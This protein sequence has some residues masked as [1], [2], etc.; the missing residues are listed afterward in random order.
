MMKNYLHVYYE[1]KTTNQRVWAEKY[2]SEHDKLH[3][4]PLQCLELCLRA[5][6]PRKE[7]TSQKFFQV[8]STREKD[9][10]ITLKEDFAAEA[11]C[12]FDVDTVPPQ[13]AIFLT[14][15]MR[16]AVREFW[17]TKWGMVYTKDVRKA[18]EKGRKGG[19]AKGEGKAK[20]GED[21]IKMTEEEFDQLI[22]PAEFDTD[23]DGRWKEKAKAPYD[24]NNVYKQ[25]TR[26]PH[27]YPTSYIYNLVFYD[28]E[29]LY[30]VD[31]A[32]AIKCGWA[33][34][35]RHNIKRFCEGHDPA[36]REDELHE[37]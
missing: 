18:Q 34:G 1:G 22:E 6:E 32:L 25:V 7:N 23:K 11:V 9:Y 12:K 24:P 14:A 35:T 30:K 33:N 4:M 21:D 17:K 8:Y 19:K 26:R 16:E 5:K 28:M 15:K 31:E 3:L 10:K 20:Q 29:E 27:V 13:C 2:L 37:V 36:G